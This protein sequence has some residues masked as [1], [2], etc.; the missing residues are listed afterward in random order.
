MRE[1]RYLPKTS[2][3]YYLYLH[4]PF[5]KKKKKKKGYLEQNE[6]EGSLHVLYFLIYVPAFSHLKKGY[7]YAAARIIRI[8]KN[9]TI[10][11][12]NSLP[13]K[14]LDISNYFCM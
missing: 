8:N 7:K 3:F 1:G 6:Q 10:K 12:G 13:K 4:P 14:I 2:F 11:K 5:F 9:K